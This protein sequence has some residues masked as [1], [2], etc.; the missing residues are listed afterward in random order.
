MN[1][2]AKKKSKRKT[3]IFN[4]LKTIIFIPVFLLYSTIIN[5]LDYDKNHTKKPFNADLNSNWVDSVFNSMTPDERL[6]QLFMISSYSRF[7]K[8]HQKNIEKMIEKY[9]IGGIVFF[10][11]G[12]VRQAILTNSYQKKSKV[13]LMIGIDGEWGLGM[14]LDST[15]S[16]PRQLM[17]GAI[18]DESIIY[19]M[20]L[21]IGHQ[22]NRLGV[23]INFAPVVD[24][25]N[26]PKNSIIVNRSF[27][28]GRINVTRK[29]YAYMVGMQD[30]KI[31]TTAKHF[32][33]HG[34]TD[35]DS[36][37]SLPVI[38]HDKKRL[39]SL[40]MYPF[41]KLIEK[42]LTGIMVAHLYIPKLDSTQNQAA[43]I[44][45]KIIS[46][47]LKNEMNFNGLVFTDALGM[48]GVSMYFDPG[49]TDLKALLAG[50]DVL[51]MSESVPEAIKQIKKAISD[52]L[53]SQEEIDKR[54]KKILKAKK[55]MGLDKFK[56]VKINNLYND[57]NTDKA[58]LIK[59]KLIESSLT[60]IQDKNDNIPI[61]NL[62]KTKIASVS[63]GNGSRTKFQHTLNLYTKIK[64]FT[65]HKNATYNEF[66]NLLSKLSA[67]DL[68][69]VGIH[70][71]HT[72]PNTFG[73]TY[74]TI[75]FIEKLSEKKKIILDLFNNPYSLNR[76]KNTDNI[77]SIIISYDDEDITQDLSAQLIFGGIPAKGLLPV[78]INSKFP[79]RTGIRKT[80]IRLKYAPPIEID[81]NKQHLEKIDSL[82]MS[83]I[84][85][86]AMP[87]C[88]VLAAK[89]GVIFYHKAFGYHTYKK[90]TAVSLNDLYDVA[91]VTKVAATLPSLMKLV[92]DKKLS[93]YKKMS[94]YIPEMKNSNKRNIS[95]KDVLTHQARLKPWIPFYLRTLNKSRN[96]IRTDLYSNSYSVYYPI[97]VYDSLY[98][99]DKYIDTMYQRIYD[100][101]LE[102]RKRYRYSDL[103]FYLFRKIIDSLS[104][105]TLDNYV[106]T[107]FYKSLGAYKLMFNPKDK[108]PLDYIVP[109][110]YDY[111]FRK[112][113]IQGYVHDYGAAMLG[114][115]SGHAG[116]F[117]NANDLA[118]IL[119]MFLQE[120]S[121]ANQNYINPITLK[122]F[123]TKPKNSYNNR[124]ALGFDRNTESG[125]GPA[126]KLVSPNSY[127]HTGFTGTIVWVDPEYQ[128][129]YVF[130][131][132]RI[133]PDIENHKL[134]EMDVRSN[135][136]QII[137][138]A[139]LNKKNAP[140]TISK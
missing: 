88:Q 51:L 91:S 46:N 112:S 29:S 118:K 52:G 2:E 35:V 37:K 73:I 39:D 22:C 128:L 120:G 42:G 14:R 124:R 72:Y 28:S 23:N 11:G 127:G 64:H 130:L 40:E 140:N 101:K 54:C 53:I 119:Q 110:E 1:Q 49:V 121:Y 77:E 138:E 89:D 48:K 103:G 108:Y 87:G 97:K 65:I 55:W 63:I 45:N 132:N 18:E 109:T 107:N 93:V 13:P 86:E 99:T 84:E 90:Q 66:N 102:R 125:A 129:I 21:E 17:L 134:I 62:D 94:H 113:I 114:G 41:K 27:G 85:Q 131:S 20:G 56:P 96:A 4:T 34:D 30:Q 5:S 10:Q 70:D 123:S 105:T 69:I 126:C 58:L 122:L 74:Q 136:Q 19:E 25:Y 116:L 80:K 15:I 38:H 32:P 8:A 16:Y 115:V 133:Y 3:I 137:Y 44:S 12:P 57:L 104:G 92:D 59:R 33:G 76:F 75:N 26:N 61:K 78:S 60:L 82:I 43:S 117:S 81:I 135:I 50:V 83:A 100:S 71:A 68:I 47:I 6:G 79:E 98:M 9:H 111:K 24:I 95:I 67:Y 106:E 139:I 31:L 7:G 36:H